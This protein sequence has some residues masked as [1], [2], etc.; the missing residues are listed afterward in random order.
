MEWTTPRPTLGPHSKGQSPKG[1]WAKPHF[2]EFLFIFYSLL[3]RKWGPEAPDHFLVFSSSR[4]F[5]LPLLLCSIFSLL[6]L[7]HLS[8]H[9][10]S[11]FFSL[12]IHFLFLL[13]FRHNLPF[14]F[15]LP[16]LSLYS[17]FL[18]IVFSIRASLAISLRYS[19]F[20]DLII[21]YLFLSA[22]P[23]FD[24]MAISTFPTILIRYP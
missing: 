16:L 24:I 6:L 19:F 15:R 23:F 21:P 9:F 5:G 14:Y 8:P 1:P 4:S 20:N 7:L 18:D 3:P 13:L 17:S 2:W 22:P 10:P 12:F 11:A